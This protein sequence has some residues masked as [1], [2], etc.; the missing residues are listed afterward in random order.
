M[1]FNTL[2]ANQSELLI[3]TIKNSSSEFELYMTKIIPIF[4]VET[5]MIVNDMSAKKRTIKFKNTKFYHDKIV[6]KPLSY[7]R[8]VNTT[9]KM[10]LENF[11]THE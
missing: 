10:M 8:N 4:V 11:K 3:I 6:K 2:I 1:R 5:S 7:V 9:F